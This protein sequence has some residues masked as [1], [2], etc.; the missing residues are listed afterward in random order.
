MSSLWFLS[1]SWLGRCLGARSLGWGSRHCFLSTSRGRRSLLVWRLLSQKRHDSRTHPV[2]GRG[3][4]G[5]A[6]R[7]RQMLSSFI[8]AMFCPAGSWGR[9]ALAQTDPLEK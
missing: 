8:T 4:E 3:K 2:V 6:R 9:V 7:R 5:R 1:C